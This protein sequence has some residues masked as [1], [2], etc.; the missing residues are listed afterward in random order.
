MADFLNHVTI[1]APRNAATTHSVSP[2]T[3]NV[4]TTAIGTGVVAGSVVAGTLF[5]PT[6]G[7]FLLCVVEAAVTSTTPTNWTLPASGSAV[8]VT[9]LYVWYRA[10]AAGSDAITTTHNVTNYPAIFDFYE[11]ASGSTF[12]TSTQATAVSNGGGAGP[13]LSGL[14]GTNWTAGA[15]GMGI[16]TTTGT[17]SVVWSSGTELVDSFVLN[18]GTD[19]YSYSLTY[20]PD[21]TAT[22]QSYAA[23]YTLTTNSATV[24]RLVFAVKPAGSAA[25]ARIRTIGKRR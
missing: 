8:N 23:T 11:F 12:G 3:A 20:T 7:R 6:A 1:A 24:E 10:S 19:G 9:G 16:N 18:S 25:A 17:A 4:G 13:V 5:T 14:T 21:N 2:S 22:S 15:A